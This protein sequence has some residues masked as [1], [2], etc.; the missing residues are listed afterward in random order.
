MSMSQINL[1]KNMYLCKND[2]IARLPKKTKIN[3]PKTKIAKHTNTNCNILR[4]EK[5][6]MHNEIVFILYFFLGTLSPKQFVH[7]PTIE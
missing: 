5:L 4:R 6:N 3:V 1:V 7:D 2:F